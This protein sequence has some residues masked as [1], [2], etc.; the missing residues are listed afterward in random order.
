MKHQALTILIYCNGKSNF[1]L[2]TKARLSPGGWLAS[3]LP[4][5]YSEK[6]MDDASKH[7]YVDVLQW[8]LGSGLSLKYSK[9]AVNY[10]LIYGFNDDIL[11]WWINSELPLKYSYWLYPYFVYRLYK[12]NLEYIFL[13]M[14][15]ALLVTIMF[16]PGQKIDLLLY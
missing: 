15:L 9:C 11:N 7:N 12:P 4:L 3:K 2:T 14:A 1:G 16:V 8:W 6:A 5:K 10:A 13:M